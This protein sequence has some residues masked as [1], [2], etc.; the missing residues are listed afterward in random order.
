VINQTYSNWELIIV[1]D[2]SNDNSKNI[3]KE[4]I[5]KDSRISSIKKNNSGVS[6]TRNIG[7]KNA[8]GDYIVFLDADDIWH[9]DNLEKKITFLASSNFDTVYSYCQ[10]IDEHS[11]PLD[12][13]LKGNHNIKL[14]DFLS[15]KANY[16]SA[17]SGIVFKKDVLQ[18]VGGFDVNLSNNA[19]QDILI[20]TLANGYKIGLIPE[21]L[22]KYRIHPENMSKKIALFEKDSLYLFKKC[23]KQNLFYSF[24]FKQQCF[25]KLCLILSGS[26]WKNGNNKFRGLYFLF[27]AIVS[28]PAS[29]ALIFNKIVNEK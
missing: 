15:L 22:W 4:Y 14:E 25:S 11:K 28:Y 21:V 2:G 20:Q 6:D 18:K 9:N 27:L 29:I 10:M 1:D 5:D 13:I 8:K 24:W 17:P 7:L 19:D 23:K 16:I 3:I 26:W 12:T